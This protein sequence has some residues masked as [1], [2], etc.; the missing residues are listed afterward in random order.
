MEMCIFVGNRVPLKSA[1]TKKITVRANMWMTTQR[2]RFSTCYKERALLQPVK[3]LISTPVVLLCECVQQFLKQNTHTKHSTRMLHKSSFSNKKRQRD[4]PRLSRLRCSNRSI[5][6]D[7][8]FS[9]TPTPASLKWRC[10]CCLLFYFFWFLPA[11]LSDVIRFV[12]ASVNMQLVST[13]LQKSV[14]LVTLATVSVTIGSPTALPRRLQIACRRAAIVSD[15]Q[16][17][18][19]VGFSHRGTNDRGAS[20]VT[21][22]HG[23]RCLSPPL[24][25][26]SPLWACVERH[27]RFNVFDAHAIT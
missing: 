3:L 17:G 7:R 21:V 10:D 6:L 27:T 25:P 2:A 9:I 18:F 24:L 16:T 13:Q 12:S 22:H 23:A 8:P 26:T 1:W 5:P 15:T 14:G 11:A 20:A 4:P 19:S